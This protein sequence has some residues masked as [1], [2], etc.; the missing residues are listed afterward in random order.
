MQTSVLKVSRAALQ[1]LFAQLSSATK[2]DWTARFVIESNHSDQMWRLAAKKI[3]SRYLIAVWH[4]SNLHQSMLILSPWISHSTLLLFCVI[5]SRNMNSQNAHLVYLGRSNEAPWQAGSIS[6]SIYVLAAALLEAFGGE[7]TA[8]SFG[9]EHLDVFRKGRNLYRA[10]GIAH[11]NTMSFAS[12]F[13]LSGVAQKLSKDGQPY[14]QAL[15]SQVNFLCT[16]MCML[17]KRKQRMF[18][19]LQADALEKLFEQRNL[20]WW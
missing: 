18:D 7:V 9:Q 20:N 10:L 8:L 17:S 16:N 15:I 19:L 11:T 13:L 1:K 14:Q 6:C 12:C 2:Q 5:G 4:M 3:L